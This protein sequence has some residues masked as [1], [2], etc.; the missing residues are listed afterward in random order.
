MQLKPVNHGQNDFLALLPLL[1][2]TTKPFGELLS[3]QTWY[4]RET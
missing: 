2:V 1:N 4:K 3:Q